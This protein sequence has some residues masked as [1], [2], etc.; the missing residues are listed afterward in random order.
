VK[1]LWLASLRRRSQAARLGWEKFIRLVARFFPPIRRLHPLPCHRF[2]AGT[3]E[4]SPVRL[5]AHAG[6]CAGGEE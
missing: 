3:R 1:Q 2:D 6:I 4:M 5:A